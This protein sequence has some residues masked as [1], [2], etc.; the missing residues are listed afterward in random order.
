MGC[1]DEWEKHAWILPGNV[2]IARLVLLGQIDILHNCLLQ[3]PHSCIPWH[4]HLWAPKP[5]FSTW[6]PR[7]KFY[8]RWE[9][10]LKPWAW[11]KS[12]GGGQFAPRISL[13]QNTY[14]HALICGH[15]WGNLILIPNASKCMFGT[16]FAQRIWGEREREREDWVP[17]QLPSSLRMHSLTSP[18]VVSITRLSSSEWLGTLWRRGPSINVDARGSNWLL[19]LKC[20]LRFPFLKPIISFGFS[21]SDQRNQ[22]LFIVLVPWFCVLHFG[23]QS[24]AEGKLPTNAKHQR[25]QLTTETTPQAL[26]LSLSQACNHKPSKSEHRYSESRDNPMP[27]NKKRKSKSLLYTN[28]KHPN[29]EMYK[30]HWCIQ[31]CNTKDECKL[32]LCVEKENTLKASNN[33]I[34]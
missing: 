24:G 33:N 2:P 21:S 16:Q 27:G 17:K 15:P 25:L 14:P 18:A 22:N 32:L 10:D 20:V 26:S 6:Y 9:D 19:L 31:N 4:S 30:P 23:D 13:L 1:R 5:Y 11:K 34:I 8:C 29:K 3:I 7:T 28:A 12:M